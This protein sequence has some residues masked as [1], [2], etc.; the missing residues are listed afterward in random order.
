M[1]ESVVNDAALMII[2][3][4]APD[5]LPLFPAF[6][7]TYPADRKR[8][9]RGRKRRGE[10][11]GFGFAEAVVVATPFVL[12]ASN[13]IVDFLAE[14]FIGHVADRAVPLLMRRVLRIEGW[15]EAPEKDDGAAGELANVDH[16]SA[17]DIDAEELR[18]IVRECASEAGVG[19][20][21]TRLVSD[22]VVGRCLTARTAGTGDEEHDR[23][24]E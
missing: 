11:L 5:E 21:L 22:A 8:A 9:L 20:E 19:P 10:T 12:F 6:S 1:Y 18:R 17:L 13:K 2:T 3:E 4:V 7:R 24:P 23:P 16:S 14:R 15:G